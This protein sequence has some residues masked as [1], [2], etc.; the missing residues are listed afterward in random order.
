M[1]I[2]RVERQF[3]DETKPNHFLVIL[4]PY[5]QDLG[6]YDGT[7]FSN[8]FLL[9]LSRKQ[10]FLTDEKSLLAHEVFHTWN[11]D[12]MGQPA[13]DATEWFTE[14]F[15]QYYQDRILLQAGLL[16]Y[17]E[18]V[19]RLNQI[20]VAYWSSPDRNWS[21]AQWLA[22][23]R[24]ENPEYELPYRRGAMI[25]LWLD[26]RIRKNTAN[27][28]S[29]DNRMFALLESPEKRLSTEFLITSLTKDLPPEDTASL[30]SYVNDGVTIPLPPELEP[31]CGTLVFENNGNPQY[32]PSD[33]V[34]CREQLKAQ[35]SK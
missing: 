26:Q 35:R 31:N 34:G 32:K 2:F 9:Y 10:T 13:G 33:Q 12:R 29:L 8:A 27:Q 5:D 22:R 4:T 25:A 16:T 24:T 18:Y 21:Q 17:P 15:T 14:G 28:R 6:S 11:P 30:R 23:T 19:D 3:W 7:V 1:S 20:L